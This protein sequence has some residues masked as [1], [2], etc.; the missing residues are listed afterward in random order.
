M[1]TEHAREF[2]GDTSRIFLMGYS[3]GGNLA[4]VVSQ[5]AKKQGIARKIK[6]QILNCPVTDVN[7]EKYPSWHENEKGY[8]LTKDDGLFAL[9]S[10]ATPKD[11]DNPELSP[12]LL[13]DLQDWPQP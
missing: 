4:T 13:K 7:G 3:A 2:G 12:M 8:L 1:I 10:V 11:Y 9:E 6:L 5:K